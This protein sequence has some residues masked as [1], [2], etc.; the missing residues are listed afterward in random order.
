MLSKDPPPATGREGGCL[1]VYS[2][3]FKD[4]RWL[5]V[6]FPRRS[7][8]VTLRVCH[9]VEPRKNISSFLCVKGLWGF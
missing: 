2:L 1:L 4:K 9:T 6:G 3:G 5:C 7:K 8:V